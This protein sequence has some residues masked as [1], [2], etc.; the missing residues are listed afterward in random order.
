MKVRVLRY[1]HGRRKVQNN[2]ADRRNQKIRTDIDSHNHP[3]A[4]CPLRST[5]RK[6]WLRFRPLLQRIRSRAILPS[7]VSAMESPFAPALETCVGQRPVSLLA[8]VST[9]CLPRYEILPNLRMLRDLLDASKGLSE[10]PPSQPAEGKL[11]ATSICGR[12]IRQIQRAGVASF[13]TRFNHSTTSSARG[14]V[15]TLELPLHKSQRH[16]D[17]SN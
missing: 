7:H 1:Q 3:P 15:M 16:A 5:V 14:P 9:N 13:A 8:L 11:D 4:T 12:G 2:C 10:G 6:R 17:G